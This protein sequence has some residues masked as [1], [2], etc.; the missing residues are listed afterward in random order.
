M[1]EVQHASVHGGV[2]TRSRNTGTAVHADIN[3]RV[4]LQLTEAVRISGGTLAQDSASMQDDNANASVSPHIVELG[5]HEHTADITTGN[6][7]THSHGDQHEIM[8]QKVHF[9]IRWALQSTQMRHPDSICALRECGILQTLAATHVGYC[10]VDRFFASSAGIQPTSCTQ[11]EPALDDCQ[12][13]G[14]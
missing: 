1:A 6:S 13:A 4:G 10:G 9:V 3:G 2:F 12:V 7:S 14:N 5:P 11:G 8:V